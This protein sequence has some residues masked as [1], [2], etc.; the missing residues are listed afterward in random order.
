M[1]A[2]HSTAK[3]VVSL[4]LV[5]LTAC[6]AG[7]P[8]RSTTEQVEDLVACVDRVRA[9]SEQAKAKVHHASD[10][11]AGLVSGGI[12]ADTGGALAVFQQAVA[13]SEAQGNVLHVAIRSLQLA[14]PP[15]FEQWSGDLLTISNLQ[16]RRRS[17]GRFDDTQLRY[18]A[19][20]ASGK[21]AAM[22]HDN[23][24]QQARDI[25]IF[26]RHDLNADSLTEIKPDVRSLGDF[27]LELDGRI[28]RCLAGAREY[29]ATASAN[30]AESRTAPT[31]DPGVGANPAR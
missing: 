22:G 11:I 12:K 10:L 15:V 1:N 9:E 26:L 19:V 23:F 14:G 21:A 13:D 27:A 24:N 20:L 29:L 4:A 8:V 5:A 3:I 6:A 30:R 2:L 7:P 17:Q 18:Q 16:L 28:D 25:A 31:R